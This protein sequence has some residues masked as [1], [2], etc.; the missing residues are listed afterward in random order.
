MGDTVL[1]QPPFP[2]SC[3]SGHISKED[4]TITFRCHDRHFR[5]AVACDESGK[6][7]FTLGASSLWTSWSLRRTLR[8]AAD[9]K[10][11]LDVRQHNQKWKEWVV[12]DPQGRQLCLVKDGV[13]KIAKATSM[14][15]QVFAEEAVG[16]HVVVD[17]QSSDHAGSKTIFRVGE[18]IIAEMSILENNDLSFLGKR[19]LERSA[20]SI[21]IAGG[22]DIA[23][24]LALAY[25][26]ALVLH[27]WRR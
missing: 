16:G 1:S 20:W 19:G 5:D 23:I 17:M 6:T 14:Q 21:R 12:E 25:C 13:S 24:I 4:T 7:L 26:R 22:I 27:A 18:A 11:I 3:N 10:H 8:S 2:I 9:D 15:A